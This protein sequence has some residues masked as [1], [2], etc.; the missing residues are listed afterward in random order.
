MSR[1]DALC[2]PV[3]CY[4]CRSGT[5][6]GIHAPAST[7]TMDKGSE[8]FKSAVSA[9]LPTAARIRLPDRRR[10]LRGQRA[11]RAPGQGLGQRVLIVDKRGHIGGNAYDHYDD[12]GILIHPYGPH[13]FHTNSARHLRLPVA[14]HPVAALRAP[15]A[16]Q[17]R[18]P[19]GADPDQPG[20]RQPA[21]RAEPRPRSRWR[22]SSRRWPRSVDTMQHLRGRGRQQGRPRALREVLPRLHAQ[23]V[24]PRSVGARR[25]RH[26]ARA[27]AHQPRRPLLHRHLPGDAAARLHAHVRAHARPSRT[28]RSCSTPTIARSRTCCPGST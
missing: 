22:S 10:R 1:G 18:R 6:C 12:A 21:L 9:T 15:R 25:Q 13:I 2:D 7:S 23:A 20:H 4:S 19:A 3:I 24:G 26:R 14:V 11:G 27:D 28:S 8:R 5:R 16:G 17:R